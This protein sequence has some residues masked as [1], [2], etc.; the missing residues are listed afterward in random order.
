MAP[1]KEINPKSAR[2]KIKTVLTQPPDPN[3]SYFKRNVLG[4]KCNLKEKLTKK[5]KLL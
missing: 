5:L 3:N 4:I 1:L 2:M